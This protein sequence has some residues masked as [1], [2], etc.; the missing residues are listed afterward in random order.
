MFLAAP[1]THHEM[2]NQMSIEGEVKNVASFRCVTGVEQLWLQDVIKA[3]TIVHHERE[4]LFSQVPER[5]SS[6]AMN[7]H[8]THMFRCSNQLVKCRHAFG[9]ARSI[10]SQRDDM[11]LASIQSNVPDSR[12]FCL[13][14]EIRR[15]AST[16]QQRST[17]S[18]GRRRT[19]L[20]WPQNGVL[21]NRPPSRK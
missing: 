1:D 7:K 10:G 21:G 17:M 6:R 3:M 16:R 15:R 4:S 14:V 11:L 18:T 2:I 20:S 13:V 5:G 19:P 8:P 12:Q 9:Y